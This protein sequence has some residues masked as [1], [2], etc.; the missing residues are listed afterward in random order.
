MHLLHV[1]FDAP[2]VVTGEVRAAALGPDGVLL[3]DKQVGNAAAILGNSIA[4]ALSDAPPVGAVTNGA[5]SAAWKPHIEMAFPQGTNTLY[6]FS[7]SRPEADGLA[8][9]ALGRSLSLTG[10][11]ALI[12]TVAVSVGFGVLTLSQVP[13]NARLGILLVVG[14]V[15]CFLASLAI[16]HG[17]ASHV[18]PMHSLCTPMNFQVF[19]GV[20]GLAKPFQPI[21]ERI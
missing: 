15:N 13:A 16:L 3:P 2:R 9:A 18:R 10:P 11:P 20:H 12:N 8:A 19:M 6:R 4:F 21:G 17:F 14:L 7:P 1:A 5:A